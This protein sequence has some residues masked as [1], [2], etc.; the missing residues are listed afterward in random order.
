[1]YG[2]GYDCILFKIEEPFQLTNHLYSAPLNHFEKFEVT[3]IDNNTV[4]IM[5]S[6]LDPI[7]IRD[8][9]VDRNQLSMLFI[10]FK[11][12]NLIACFG[13]SESYIGHAVSRLEKKLNLKK[14]EK[15]NLFNFFKQ[16]VLR[17]NDNISFVNSN[18]MIFT[19]IH[20]YN[21]DKN[22]FD[23]EIDDI[24]KVAIKTINDNELIVLLSSN[25]L[26]SLTFKLIEYNI[27]FYIDKQSVL[28]FPETIED[29]DV[30]NAIKEIYTTRLV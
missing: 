3:N 25:Y 12:Q 24:K 6:W 29:V 9:I 28:S 27:S 26:E 7:K 19:N 15:V 5:Y 23:C 20:L 21:G 8:K 1:M 17:N 4:K 16:I 30:L 2:Y 10:F 14:L 18:K 11:N 13:S 22:L